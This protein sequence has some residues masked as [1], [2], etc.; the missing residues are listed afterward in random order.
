MVEIRNGSSDE[1]R[2]TKLP[3]RSHFLRG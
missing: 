1:R 3:F 2:E